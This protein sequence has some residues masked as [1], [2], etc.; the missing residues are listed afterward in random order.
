MAAA[1]FCCSATSRSQLLQENTSAT[2]TAL[3][4]PKTATHRMLIAQLQ[5]GA[6]RRWIHIPVEHPVIESYTSVVQP[7]GYA[8]SRR[9][10]LFLSPDGSDA[11]LSHWIMSNRVQSSARSVIETVCA[12]TM[13]KYK[14][15]F[16]DR[17]L[18]SIY[19]PTRIVDRAGSKCASLS[20]G[21]PVERCICA[22]I[23]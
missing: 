16:A 9:S 4:P 12:H 3:R 14:V 5:S 21:R 11:G 23:K 7:L 13:R 20:H 18:H 6:D 10:A 15:T 19:S 22:S 17:C 1:P 2:S 8:A